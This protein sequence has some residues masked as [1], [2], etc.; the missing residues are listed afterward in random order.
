MAFSRFTN[1]GRRLRRVLPR[2]L[3]VAVPLAAF[4]CD[5]ASEPVGPSTEAEPP[6][7][8]ATAAA[9]PATSSLVTGDRIAFILWQNFEPR[10][11]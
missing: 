1:P 11:L 2:F 7:D 8:A 5:G 6:T 9:A 3:W 4:G 10:C